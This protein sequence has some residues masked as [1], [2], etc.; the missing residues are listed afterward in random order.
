[1]ILLDLSNITYSSLHS[2]IAQGV[3]ISEDLLRHIILNCI[4]SHNLKNRKRFGDLVIACD[5]RHTW[6]KDAFPYYKAA[7]K[8]ARDK[9]THINWPEV[10]E[11]FNLIKEELKT[12]FPYKVIDVPNAEADDVIAVLSSL[13]KTLIISE[14]E[15]L[16]QCQLYGDC[17][18]YAPIRKKFKTIANLELFLKEHIIEGDRIDGIPNILSPDDVFVTGGRQKALTAS[19]REFFINNNI[20]AYPEENRRYFERNRELI[21][22][23]YIPSELVTEIRNNYTDQPKKTKKHLFNY[24]FDKGL[25]KHISAIQEF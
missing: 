8:A 25:T 17:E 4:R 19:R 9:Q 3:T 7:R 5:S 23:S 12:F 16:M 20:D 13:E 15:D 22:L 6:R 10:F 14:D 21:D 24:F 18:Q 11:H 2:A 1:M